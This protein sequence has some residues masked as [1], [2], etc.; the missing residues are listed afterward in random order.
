MIVRNGFICDS[1]GRPLEVE[2][3]PC[4]QRARNPH[5][6]KY[7]SCSPYAHSQLIVAACVAKG[8]VVTEI[9]RAVTTASCY[10][11]VTSGDTHISVRVSDHS[12]HGMRSNGTHVYI[13]SQ[14]V[15]RSMELIEATI[16][17]RHK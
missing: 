15:A 16:A 5:L 17:R 6:T 4:K 11:T 13:Q 7:R 1:S 8:L 12:K 14:G 10:F 2:Y 9:R 3:Q